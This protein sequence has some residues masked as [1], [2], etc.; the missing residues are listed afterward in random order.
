[1]ND[2]FRL[3]TKRVLLLTGLAAAASLAGIARADDNS[4]NPSTGA[5]Y[6][7]FDDGCS[8]PAISNPHFDPS[9]SAWRQAHPNGLSERELQARSSESWAWRFRRVPGTAQLGA[10]EPTTVAQSSVTRSVSARRKPRPRGRQTGAGPH[11]RAGG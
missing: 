10:Q 6:A 2:T 8:E 3:A 1:M 5:S 9:L 7:G 4:V 11:D